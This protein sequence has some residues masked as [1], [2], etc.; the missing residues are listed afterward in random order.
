MIDIDMSLVASII[1]VLALMAV[2]NSMLYKPVRK[3]LEEREG[4]MQAIEADAE[5]YARRVDKLVQ[6]FERRMEEARQAGKAEFEKLREEAREEERQLL[7]TAQQEAEKKRTELLS[8]L[9]SQVEAARKEL[10]AQAEV[11]ASE[12]AQKLLGRAV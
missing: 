4:K 11:F 3:I 8:Q 1:A 12:I 6:D 2:L 9:A 5:S 7:E 10:L